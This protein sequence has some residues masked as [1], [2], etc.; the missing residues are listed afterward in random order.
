MVTGIEAIYEGGEAPT[1]MAT[2][3]ETLSLVPGARVTF[4]LILPG[5]SAEPYLFETDDGLLEERVERLYV[6]W[7]GGAGVFEFGSTDT[8]IDEATGEV[9]SMSPFEVPEALEDG[10]TEFP[11]HAVVYD[12]RGG[13]G[14]IT[15]MAQI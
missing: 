10:Q 1:S 3:G 2:P 6:G 8:Y 4:N 11:I 13:I 14:W 15:I 5:T 12:R 9:K 7:Y